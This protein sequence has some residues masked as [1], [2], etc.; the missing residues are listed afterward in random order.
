[1]VIVNCM[2]GTYEIEGDREYAQTRV[3]KEEAIEDG[4]TYAEIRNIEMQEGIENIEFL[5]LQAIENELDK[6]SK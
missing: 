1:M 3:E 6:E 4:P 2:R 5:A